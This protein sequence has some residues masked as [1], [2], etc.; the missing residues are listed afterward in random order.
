[1]TYAVERGLAVD[2]ELLAGSAPASSA[3]SG[4]L[5]AF[6][7]TPLSRWAWRVTIH[8][9]AGYALSLVGLLVITVLLSLTLGLAVTVILAIPALALLVASTHAFTRLHLSRLDTLLGVQI[10]ATR[11]EPPD[12]GLSRLWAQARARTTW[13]QVG[14]H[15]IAPLI[16]TVNVTIVVSMWS[17]GLAFTPVV[18]YSWALPERGLFDWPMRHPALLA[19]VTIIGLFFLLTAPWVAGA[20]AAV[21][22][23]LARRLLGPSRVEELARRVDVLTASREGVVDAADAERRRIERDLHDGTQQRLVSLAMNLGM[24]RAKLADA[25][26]PARRAVEE[27]HEEAKQALAEL[28]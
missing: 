17:V 10:P 23:A 5:T 3:E 22:V 14:Y 20:L 21:D 19:A 8:H 7:R 9:V 26:E 16:S 28:R 2:R 11:L 25:P 15:L 1:M 6:L 18:A 12:S 27:A 13:R 4:G 24:A